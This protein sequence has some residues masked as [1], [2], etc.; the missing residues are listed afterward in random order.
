MI[1]V[2]QCP[3]VGEEYTK[4]A[5]TAGGER[6]APTACRVSAL[7]FNTP[8]PGHQRPLSQSEVSGFVRIVADE[9]VEIEAEPREGFSAA[10][11]RPLSKGVCPRRHG[12]KVCFTLEEAGQYVL[13][14]DGEH[15]ALHIFL[16]RP[17]DFSV[18]GK[19]TRV[20][21]AGL[22]DAGRIVLKD[23]DRIFLEEGARVRGVLY[24]K[25]VH[26]AAVYG[27][28]VLDGGGEERNSPDCYG[29]DTNGCLKLYECENVRIDGVTFVDSAIWVCNLFACTNVVLNDIKV[30]GHWKY[31][32]DGVDIVNSSDITVKN[33]FIRAFDDVITLKGI[34]PYR[35]LP[36]ENILV[37]NCVL[38][39]GWGRTLEIGLETL[40]ERYKNI[41]FRNCDLIRNSA[42]AIDIQCGD[43]AEISDISY[44]DIRV[45]YRADCLPEQ[46][47]NP[48]GCRYAGY[49]K[50]HTPV[51]IKVCTQEYTLGHPFEEYD[52]E[53]LRVR[54]G[55]AARV[56]DI[57]FENVSALLEAGCEPPQIVFDV[58][59]PAFLGGVTMKNVRVCPAREEKK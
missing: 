39:C 15:T 6:I 54:Q 10:S 25:G 45:E 52:G 1:R 35:Q 31:N 37:E 22:H 33:S 51:F 56:H 5:L 47:E 20:F 8:W 21:G 7:P 17:R 48:V 49:G 14:F 27:C 43:Y 19:P 34:L 50:K 9:P 18:Y 32:C 24:G 59:E 55:R 26:D 23:G 46:M 53:L 38:W 40:A 16:C 57:R 41:S 44:E 13:E 42:V 3:S 28:G 29:E 4:I 58:K 11:V 12:K 30:V 2:L 36:L